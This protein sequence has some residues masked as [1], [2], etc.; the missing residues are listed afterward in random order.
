MTNNKQQT[1][2]NAVEYLD[3]VNQFAIALGHRWLTYWRCSRADHKAVES[4]QNFAKVANVGL[5]NHEQI[6]T[7]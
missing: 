6:V 2:M 1:E 5:I 4:L 7:A 3:K